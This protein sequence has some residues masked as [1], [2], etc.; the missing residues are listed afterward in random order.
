[1]TL[2]LMKMINENREYEYGCAML[3]FDFPTL[4]KIQDVINPK[5]IYEDPD[6]DSFGLEDEP[7]I[8][9]LFGLHKEVTDEEVEDI[10][11]SFVYRPIK[12]SKLS[13]F[14]NPDYDVLKFDIDEKSRGG[15][16][17]YKV[18]KE[19]KKLPF[20]SNFPDYHP[21]M[22]VGYLKSGTGEKWSE[23]INI[24]DFTIVPK[25]VIYSKP[26]ST[27]LKFEIRVSQ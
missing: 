23:K 24:G 3:Y 4:L 14:D 19:L 7:H 2:K 8:T 22:T 13:I 18:N 5:D 27:K 20:T 11:K 26:D 17:L 16:I 9:L 21:H 15:N 1:M 6:D 12:L 25:F 10:V